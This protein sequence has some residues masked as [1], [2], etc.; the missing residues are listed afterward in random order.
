[1][2]LQRRE[3]RCRVWQRRHAARRGAGGRWRRRAR[4][5][6]PGLQHATWCAQ[7]RESPVGREL[8]LPETPVS[9]PGSAYRALLGRRFRALANRRAALDVV[10]ILLRGLRRVRSEQ[11]FSPVFPCFSSVFPL[12]FHCF[13]TVFH[14]FSTVF[15]LFSLFFTVFPLFFCE[16]RMKQSQ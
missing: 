8:G 5:C 10:R 3:W 4:R 1:M 2:R 7:T 15:P 11:L 13:S 16:A 6:L 12:F 9:G 14:C